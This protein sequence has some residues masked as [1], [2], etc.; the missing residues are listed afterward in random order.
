MRSRAL[1]RGFG[2]A[3]CVLSG[4]IL[5]AY[6]DAALPPDV[7]VRPVAVAFILSA[8][9]SPLALVSG[10]GGTVAIGIL[11]ILLIAWSPVFLLVGAT[12]GVVLVCLSISGHKVDLSKPLLVGAAMFAL[13]GLVRAIEVTELAGQESELTSVDYSR[14]VYI[15]LLDGYPRADTLRALGISIDPFIGELESRGFDH[16]PDARSIHS[17]TYRTLA[18]MFGDSPDEDGWGTVEDRRAARRKLRL[19]PGFISASKRLDYDFAGPGLNW[20]EIGLIGRTP[21]ASFE[22]VQ[23][24]VVRSLR[25]AAE[26]VLTKLE[27]TEHRHVFAHVM[28]PHGPFLYTRSGEVPLLPPCWPECDPFDHEIGRL[29]MSMDDWVDGMSAFLTYLNA[30]VL[31]VL[32]EI[33]SRDPTALVIVLSDH[34]A[35]YSES[36]TP[37]WFRS[38]LV[39][40]TPGHPRAFGVEPTPRHVVQT[41]LSLAGSASGG[42]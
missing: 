5:G 34:G 11:S 40:R 29:Q 31:E 25:G 38:F 2:V 39:A 4:V 14:G 17:Y 30:R 18:A 27:H 16:Y 9:L 33:V 1:F 24:T 7:L 6:A 26:A 32:D 12:L 22:N 21:I 13:V 36:N 3:F 19:P 8:A 35:R 41:A 23:R 10:G 15:V 28:A 20:F 42:D 37:E